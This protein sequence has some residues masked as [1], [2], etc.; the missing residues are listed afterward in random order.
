M[1]ESSKASVEANSGRHDSSKRAHEMKSHGSIQE[2]VITPNSKSKID[3]S[4]QVAEHNIVSPAPEFAAA[5][6][7]IAIA[8]ESYP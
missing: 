7:K 4:G 8:V 2:L 1:M 6:G 3:I 5:G